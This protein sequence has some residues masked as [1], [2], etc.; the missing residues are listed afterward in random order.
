MSLLLLTRQA[1]VCLTLQSFIWILFMSL[2]LEAVQMLMGHFRVRRASYD[3]VMSWV[4]KLYISIVFCAASVACTC[5]NEKQTDHLVHRLNPC[6]YLLLWSANIIASDNKFPL[7]PNFVYVVM[8]CLWRS[9]TT[10]IWVQMKH[11]YRLFWSVCCRY[12]FDHWLN[13]DTQARL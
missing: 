11:F 10:T 13:F 1:E 7:G 3:G 2:I 12:G 9:L 5:T 8:V 6:W 4:M